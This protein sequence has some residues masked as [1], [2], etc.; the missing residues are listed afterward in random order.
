MHGAS[1]EEV[2]VEVVDSLAAIAG[3]VD[4][5]AVAF[6]EIFL[7]GDFSGGGE[8]LAK[9]WGVA[10]GGFGE[11][12]D[13]AARRDENVSRRGRV[14]VSEG[15]AIVVLVDGGGGNASVNDFAKETAHE[16][17]LGRKTERN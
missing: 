9:E 6:D 7:A 5:G 1:A 12:C 17:L 11:R 4:D 14:D 2:D 15:K 3:G 8:E 10:I 13:V 16:N